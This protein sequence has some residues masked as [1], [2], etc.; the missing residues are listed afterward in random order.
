MADV[1]LLGIF[2]ATLLAII[3]GTILTIYFVKIARRL[4]SLLEVLQD[5][6]ERRIILN[7]ALP[8]PSPLPKGKFSESE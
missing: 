8:P 1:L 4:D 6:A 2:L 5:E 7:Y 3:F